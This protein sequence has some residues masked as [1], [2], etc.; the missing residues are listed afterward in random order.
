M[1]SRRKILPELFFASTTWHTQEK[2]DSICKILTGLDWALLKQLTPKRCILTLH[3][4]RQRIKKTYDE[5]FEAIYTL[6]EEPDEAPEIVKNMLVN[7]A[8]I[9][10]A[11]DDSNSTDGVRIGVQLTATAIHLDTVV[12]TQVLGNAYRYI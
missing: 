2:L 4:K 7:Q 11:Q 9:E 10:S 12:H 1:L 5:L 6:L 8:S 3:D